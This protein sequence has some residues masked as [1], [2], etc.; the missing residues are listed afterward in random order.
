MPRRKTGQHVDGWLVF[1]KP[2]GMTSTHA[3][4]VVRRAFDARKAGHAGTLDPLAT[5]VLPVALG[6]ATKTV[7][8]AMNGEK[9]YRFSVRWGVRTDSDDAE[10]RIV[11]T[12]HARPAR[13]AIVALLP[14]FTGDIWQMPP[15]FSAVKLSGARAYDLARG[16]ENVVL[17]PRRVHIGGLALLHVPDRDTA[18]F[19]A[20]CG[21]GTYVRALARDLGQA[22]GCEGHLVA[23]R[24]T[25]VGAFE[26]SLAVTLERLQEAAERG[27]DA[28]R[29]LLL[30]LETALQG[31]PALTVSEADANRLKM[32][33]AVLIRG[34]DAP[35]SGGPAYAL[36]R[37]RPVA[38]GQIEK[39]ELRPTRVFRL[40][41]PG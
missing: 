1:D 38:L 24:R 14:T 33:Q 11:A 7:A 37:G 41:S 40:G 31:L 32:G 30:P 13:D 28:L 6:E 36:C 4:A 25:R 8:Y 29:S 19:E 5:G 26:E 18:E 22:L 12:S 39:G 23:L 27:L 21:K 10:G 3:V 34:R 17:E 16:G 9:V 35:L 2:A 20:R 15:K